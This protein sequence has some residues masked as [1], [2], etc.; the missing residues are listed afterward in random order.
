MRFFLK[1]S[2]KVHIELPEGSTYALGCNSY[3]SANASFSR[4]NFE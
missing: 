4:I 1:N 2:H 3:P